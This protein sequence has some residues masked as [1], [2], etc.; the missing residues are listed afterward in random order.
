MR[1]FIRRAAAQVIPGNIASVGRAYRACKAPG[2]F[3]SFVAAAAVTAIAAGQADPV[4]KDSS[5]VAIKGYD[6]VA[7]FTDIGSEIA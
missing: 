2:V 7:Y 6:A 1:W 3:F 5:G 4:N